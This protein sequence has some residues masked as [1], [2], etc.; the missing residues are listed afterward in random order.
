MSSTHPAGPFAV[1]NPVYYSKTALT[2]TVN[3]II[4]M[5]MKAYST[6]LSTKKVIKE[7]SIASLMF[8]LTPVD[9]SGQLKMTIMFRVS[10]LS[11]NYDVIR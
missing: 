8:Q 6:P 1:N 10:V 4:L 3:M 7:C 11:K 2:M 9:D 5:L